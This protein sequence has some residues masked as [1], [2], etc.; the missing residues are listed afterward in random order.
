MLGMHGAYEANLTMHGCD[1]MVSIG[2]RFDDRVAGRLDA[3]APG[4]KKIHVDIDP[5]R[6]TRT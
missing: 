4:A 6:S 1:V 2:A 5:P 3:F